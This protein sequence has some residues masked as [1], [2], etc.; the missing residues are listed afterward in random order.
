M[1]IADDAANTTFNFLYTND[2]NT[3]TLLNAK[4]ERAD[5]QLNYSL[6]LS[7]RK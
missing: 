5:T 4:L 2:G 1:F 7:A 6:Q 3:L